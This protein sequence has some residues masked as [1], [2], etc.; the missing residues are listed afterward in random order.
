M[1][2][3][4]RPEWLRE[5]RAW[6]EARLA[7]RGLEVLADM[8]Q[9]HM[10]WWSTVLRVRTS[11]GVVW[12]KATRPVHRFEMRLTPLLEA[13]HPRA[14]AEVVA[15]DAE[16]GWMLTRDA[17]TRLRDAASGREQLRHWE[18]LL[19][20]YAGLQ[21]DLASK[22]DELLE[23][24]VPD[25]RLEVMPGQLDRVLADDEAV[26]FGREDGLTDEE[27]ERLRAFDFRALCR[28]LTDFGLPETLQHDDFHDGNVFLRGGSYVFFDWGDGCV[29]HP[30]H[31]L[32][33][34]LRAAAWKLG[35]EPGAPEL[36][37]L[38]DAYLEPW[39]R[40]GSPHELVAASELARQTGTVQRALAW[41]RFVSARP[42]EA[43]PEDADSVPYGL[44][45]L[46]ADRPFG[47]WAVEDAASRP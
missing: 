17:G 25:H 46:L 43:R 44:K 7:E 32:V 33:V 16:R 38:R 3:W 24:G 2:V 4:T 27:R 34:T 42:A 11:D 14:T 15:V 22:R 10:Y 35:F 20:E 36:L 40:F 19:P 1:D 45:L 5:A 30:F 39:R 21:I 13:L 41:H 26:L 12:F 31:T 9:P 6:I 23:L 29:S 47:A 18:E 28:R 8:T 37:R